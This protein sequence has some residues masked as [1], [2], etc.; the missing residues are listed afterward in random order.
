MRSRSVDQ[1]D[2]D[3][4]SVKKIN[5]QQDM[6]GKK[7]PRPKNHK[8]KHSETDMKFSMVAKQS[9]FFKHLNKNQCKAVNKCGHQCCGFDMGNHEEHCPEC[10]EC[11]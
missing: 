1:I 4:A 2:E 5:L 10:I 3:Q 7:P 9:K 6:S 11:Q 8:S